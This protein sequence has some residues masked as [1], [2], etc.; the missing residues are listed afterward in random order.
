[1]R[2]GVHDRARRGRRARR[3]R[4]P[5]PADRPSAGRRRASA[6][7]AATAARP[8]GAPPIGDQ[9]LGSIGARSRARSR[10]G[11]RRG[12]TSAA[13]ARS[14]RVPRRP[15]RRTRCRRRAG[16]S[17]PACAA[18]GAA[19]HTTPSRPR[20]VH[21]SAITASCADG[22]VTA[23][24]PARAVRGLRHAAGE[25]EVGVHAEPVGSLL[26]AAQ[27]DRRP[28]GP[29]EAG[30]VLVDAGRR[31]PG[32][33]AP[34]SAR[35]GDSMTCSLVDQE[36]EVLDRRPG[37][38]P[39]FGLDLVAPDDHVGTRAERRQV[40]REASAGGGD[41]DGRHLGAPVPQPVAY[42]LLAVRAAALRSRSSDPPSIGVTSPVQVR[43]RTVA[44][45][46]CQ[47]VPVKVYSIPQSSPV[48]TWRTGESRRSAADT[49][50]TS[51]GRA[52]L[53]A[54]VP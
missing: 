29:M 5:R 43:R 13:A 25:R 41:V 18:S 15:P 7:A 20:P 11:H 14:R 36:R 12:R 44:D 53:Q 23:S 50:G 3:S 27:D 2:R 6:P 33:D 49:K 4:R 31:P 28:P 19:A 48:A 8:A 30:A 24:A 16:T 35:R 32:R 21:C 37:R 51:H 42:G 26:G 54:R 40:R 34:P 22:D 47:A 38:Q 17:A 10:R 39:L 45:G 1:M 9:R 46:S 52:A